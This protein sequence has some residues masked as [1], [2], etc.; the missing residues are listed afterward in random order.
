M[1]RFGFL[2]FIISF[3]CISETS[4]SQKRH[5]FSICFAPAL[6][7]VNVDNFAEISITGFNKELFLRQKPDTPGY[8]FSAE[9]LYSYRITSHLSVGVGFGI[10]K[11]KSSS[12]AFYLYETSKAKTTY[13]HIYRAQ[14][15]PFRI[16]YSFGSKR[17]TPTVAIVV[18][19]EFFKK[20][21]MKVYS[22]NNKT[23]MQSN[24]LTETHYGIKYGLA[25]IG[26]G[27]CAGVRV[28]VFDFFSL[29]FLP[30]F[31][32]YSNAIRVIKCPDCSTFIGGDMW[33][34]GI[35]TMAT[36]SF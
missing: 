13:D 24:F 34:L 22:I 35:Q 3:L 23:G 1:R 17:I 11:K 21:E 26:A 25:R 28:R 2:F 5:D 8:G 27:V 29:S 32:Y 31:R 19:P 7:G 33:R 12:G 6:T 16:T 18:G 20:F 10:S 4:F 30:E 15:I 14:E 9:I 36:A